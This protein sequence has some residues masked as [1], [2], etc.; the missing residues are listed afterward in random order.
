[1]INVEE[2]LKLSQEERRSLIETIW[3][4]LDSE[5]DGGLTKEQEQELNR[6]IERHERGES[7]SYSWEELKARLKMEL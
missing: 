1:M 4:S 3:D 7:K 5:E 6:R 2:I